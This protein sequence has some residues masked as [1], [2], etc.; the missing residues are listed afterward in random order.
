MRRD[1]RRV[2]VA[3][4]ALAGVLNVAA[5]PSDAQALRGAL[6]DATRSIAPRFDCDLAIRGTPIFQE[7]S[8][9]WVAFFMAEG[10]AC[11]AAVE[12]LAARAKP[13]HVLLARR[14]TLAQVDKQVRATL[15]SVRSSFHCLITL[16]G[17]PTFQDASGDWLVTYI[18]SGSD[19]D[20]A[21]EQL[22]E[23]GKELQIGFVRNVARQ[24]L[25]R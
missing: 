17:D 15:S 18:A 19:C 25:L 7:L 6:E 2:A 5:Q 3:A 21:A 23:L 11:D 14:P 13:L 16:R 22:A 20:A 24:D 8:G 4:A 10:P 9:T 1:A 12:A